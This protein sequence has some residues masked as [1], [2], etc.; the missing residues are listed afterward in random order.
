M[1]NARDTLLGHNLRE[2]KRT[3]FGRNRYCAII[4][5]LDFQLPADLLAKLRSKSP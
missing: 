2:G 1:L 4:K 5:P 3:A